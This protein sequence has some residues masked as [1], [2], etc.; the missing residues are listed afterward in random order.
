MQLLP[1]SEQRLL[2]HLAV[3]PAGI[4]LEAATAVTGHTPNAAPEVAE[5]IADLV[6]K[7]LVTLGESAAP[8]Q[9]AAAGDDPD[10]CGHKAH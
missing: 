7:S 1:A 2:A 3:F 6:A 5:G 10:L 8:Q 9:V 4:S